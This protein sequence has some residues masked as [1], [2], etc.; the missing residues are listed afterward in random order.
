MNNNLK[1]IF[2]RVIKEYPGITLSCS[3]NPINHN[4]R[5]FVIRDTH[6]QVIAKVVVTD[7]DCYRMILKAKATIPSTLDEIASS[8]LFDIQYN[9]AYSE[10]VIERIFAALHKPF[11]SGS[12]IG[13]NCSM[14]SEPATKKVEEHIFHD[15][16]EPNRHGLTAYVCEKHFNIIMGVSPT[17]G[18]RF[19]EKTEQ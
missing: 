15:D 19:V 17:R 18:D 9:F 12:C 3:I 13:E 5:H 8:M 7:N 2:D 4:N 1:Y 6:E 11:I 10:F 16:P 14:C